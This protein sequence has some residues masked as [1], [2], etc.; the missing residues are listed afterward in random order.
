MPIQKIL[1]FQ[2]TQ[3]F[4][5]RLKEA[6]SRAELKG[7]AKYSHFFGGRHENIYVAHKDIPEISPL[8]EKVIDAASSRTKLDKDQLKVGFWFN[9]MG[10]GHRTEPHTHDDYDEVL[11]VVY[12]VDAPEYSG[13]L[14]LTT[15]E[16]VV[17]MEPEDGAML[18]FDPTFEHEVTENRSHKTRLSVAFNIGPK[19]S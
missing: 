1:P 4:N 13:D 18:V 19:Q 11:S 2:N 15:D 5:A 10:P 14:L 9:K 16:G 12:Y 17:R 3:A 8:I 6:F 7:I